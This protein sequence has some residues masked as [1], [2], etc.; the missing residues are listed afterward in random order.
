M[1]DWPWPVKC[2][3]DCPLGPSVLGDLA[4][5]PVARIPSRAELSVGEPASRAPLDRQHP[6]KKKKVHAPQRPT[7]PVDL[8]TNLSSVCLSNPLL[9]FYTDRDPGGTVRALHF[10]HWA[11][12]LS[13]RHTRH[14]FLREHLSL[15]LHPPSTVA[16]LL[17]SWWL[18]AHSASL[19]C[20][21]FFNPSA[22]AP[23][24][25]QH[26]LGKHTSRWLRHRQP[27]LLLLLLPQPV[28]PRC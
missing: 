7:V 15:C 14:K 27:T 16:S 12:F 9:F 22:V 25:S 8:N 20:L 18:A 11:I 19:A 26:R 1:I 17:Q 3:L 10:P 28:C 6:K 2:L 21:Y 24:P 5:R 13:S 23:K 4:P